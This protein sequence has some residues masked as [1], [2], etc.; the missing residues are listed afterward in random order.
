MA[1]L[2]C[3]SVLIL[4]TGFILAGDKSWYAE[5][6]AVVLGGGLAN[7]AGRWLTKPRG[8]THIRDFRTGREEEYD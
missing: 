5:M 2:I 7:S 4:L 6:M 8:R 3:L 1:G